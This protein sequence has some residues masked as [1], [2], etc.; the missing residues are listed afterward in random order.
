MFLEFGETEQAFTQGVV[1]D[2]IKM[3]PDADPLRVNTYEIGENNTLSE[4]GNLYHLEV[5]DLKTEYVDHSCDLKSEIKVED[6]PVPISFPVVKSEVDEGSFDVDR[7]QQKQK[8]EVSSQEDEVL[9]ESG[10]SWMKHHVKVQIPVP[11]PFR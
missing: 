3:E 2:V 6:T 9:T 4:E 8:V 11:Y 5:T 7:V 10:G 1:M